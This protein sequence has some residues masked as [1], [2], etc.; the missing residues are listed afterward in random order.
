MSVQVKFEFEPPLC[1]PGHGGTADLFAE[2]AGLCRVVVK[3]GTGE[4]LGDGLYQR[5]ETA[6]GKYRLIKGNAWKPVE[7]K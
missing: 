1:I 3:N 4:V 5:E 7:A 2:G 6:Q